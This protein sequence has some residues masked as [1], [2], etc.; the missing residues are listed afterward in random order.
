MVIDG[1]RRLSRSPVVDDDS[2]AFWFKA[3]SLFM[4]AHP[5]SA[6]M[7]SLSC[8]VSVSW[9]SALCWLSFAGWSTSSGISL[10]IPDCILQIG[11][12]F[13]SSFSR[14]SVVQFL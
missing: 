13:S 4:G 1:W 14:V 10:I 6:R 7:S 8:A 3:F 5:A 2:I 11:V 9:S 12:K